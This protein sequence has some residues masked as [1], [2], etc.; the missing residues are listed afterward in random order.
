M[1]RRA[2]LTLLAA[3]L[4]ALRI[5]CFSSHGL[6]C[7][8]WT[9]PFASAGSNPQRS[10]EAQLRFRSHAELMRLHASDEA[11]VNASRAEGTSSTQRAGSGGFS[12]FGTGPGYLPPWN[13]LS[14]LHNEAG[15][16]AGAA[17]HRRRRSVEGRASQKGAT[18]KSAGRDSQRF[19][20]SQRQGG[21]ARRVRPP[22]HSQAARRLPRASQCS[23][24]HWPPR[25]SSSPW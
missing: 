1:H 23:I 7:L 14:E 6:S 13:K 18:A 15:G 9:P 3:Y 5:S 24:P 17:W 4:A 25:R 21:T 11:R 20:D 8:L 22:W 12:Y 10:Q 19:H 16:G 2:S